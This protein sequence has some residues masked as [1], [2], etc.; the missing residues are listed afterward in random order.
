MEARV[1][2]RTDRSAGVIYRG[3]MK[4]LI[5]ADGSPYSQGAARHLASHVQ[6]FAEPPEV[7][8]VHVHPA[9]PYPGATAAAGKA[10]VESY[11]RE[12]SQAALA[13]VEK[14]LTAAGIA[15]TAA[16]KVG[17]VAPKLAAYVKEHGIDLVVMGTHGHGALANLALGS[18]AT[19][20]IA[21]LDVP[22]MVV[23][24]PHAAKPSK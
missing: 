8:V 1:R 14:E 20:L 9:L 21:T 5:A 19:K 23:R 2:Y 17:E 10:A 16:W 24:T 11:Q 3:P 13:N 4:I 6:W 7:H 15:Y 22:V 18:V 12:E